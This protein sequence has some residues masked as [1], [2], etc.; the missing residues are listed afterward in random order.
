MGKSAPSRSGIL[1]RDYCRKFPAASSWELARMLCRDHPRVFT[2]PDNARSAIRY[3]RGL[4]DGKGHRRTPQ[5][6]ALDIPEAEPENWAPVQFPASGQGLILADPHVPYH[7][8]PALSRA[9]EHAL[10][11]GHDDFCLILGDGID[12]YQLSRF[13]KDPEKRNFAGELAAMRK[14]L[15]TLTTH[16]GKVVYKLG[17]HERRYMTFMRQHCAQFL[18]IREFDLARLL[19]QWDDDDG[20]EHQIDVTFVPEGVPMYAGELNLLHGHEYPGGIG[21][22]AKPARTMFLKAK[23]CTISGHHHQTDHNNETDIR[24]RLISCWTVGCLAHLH[25]EFARLNRW[26]HG[27]ALFEYDGE[28]QWSI[29]NKRII[30]G[31]VV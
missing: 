19:T 7:D 9:I 22:P 4:R 27:F 29:G 5:P 6:I 20:T 11:R 16:F 25:P 30:D 1:A 10:H 13:E 24:G 14:L 15:T 28:K 8:K 23:R 12:F 26:N 18:G 3:H 31:R 17:N 21:A 2:T